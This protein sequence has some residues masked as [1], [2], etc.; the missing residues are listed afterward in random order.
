MSASALLGTELN[1]AVEAF[2]KANSSSR[3]FRNVLKN[4]L[5]CHSNLLLHFKVIF[6]TASVEHVTE[7]YY[8][9]N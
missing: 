7:I 2:L 5:Q 6:V 4:L 3:W 9:V 1:A 8:R